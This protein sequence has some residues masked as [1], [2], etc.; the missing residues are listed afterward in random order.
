MQR[1]SVVQTNSLE[2][3]LGGDE[4]DLEEQE[5]SVEKE[6]SEQEENSDGSLEDSDEEEKSLAERLNLKRRSLRISAIGRG[7]RDHQARMERQAE[8]E[9]GKP[10]AKKLNKK[11][12]AEATARLTASPTKGKNDYSTA[13]LT[14]RPDLL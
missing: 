4:S 11:A 13:F 2:N 12:Q 14:T 3:A 7:K 9:G 1:K 8:E 10:N 5:E 6:E